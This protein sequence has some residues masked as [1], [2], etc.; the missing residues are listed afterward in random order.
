MPQDTSAA[1]AEISDAHISEPGVLEWFQKEWKM[2]PRPLAAEVWVFCR[3]F[4]RV[5]VVE[6][7][8]RGLVPPGGR[9]E[10]WETVREGAARELAEETGLDLDLNERPAF[11]AARSYR[12]DWLPTLYVAYWATADEDSALISE[13]GQPARWVDLDSDWRTFHSP[14]VALIRRFAAAKR[15][16]MR[17]DADHC[18]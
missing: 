14:D 6:H 1:L 15:E 8:W 3:A 5:L 10:V 2:N 9:V 12:K 13:P 4:T 7:R 18:S 16:E 11:A 17:V